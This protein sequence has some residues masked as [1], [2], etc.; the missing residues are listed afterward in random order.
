MDLSIII[1][2]STQSHEALQATCEA[3]DTILRQI[4]V[5][6]YETQYYIRDQ[7]KHAPCIEV[8]IDDYQ[9]LTT[10]Q[11][12]RLS[13]ALKTIRSLQISQTNETFSEF[14]HLPTVRTAIL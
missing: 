13:S 3:L 8:Y 6:S 9:D 10:N 14:H 7:H 11:V 1:G 5:K 4:G 2:E 12:N